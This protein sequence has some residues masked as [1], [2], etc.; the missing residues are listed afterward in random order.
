MKRFLGLLAVVAF[1]CCAWAQNVTYQVKYK[2]AY[3]MQKY[4]YI[5]SLSYAEGKILKMGDTA[6]SINGDNYVVDNK[7]SDTATDTRKMLQYT[8]HNTKGE[9]FVICFSHELTFPDEL[10][11]QVIIFNVNN[12]YHWQ[13]FITDEGK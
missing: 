13:Y 4:E 5:D 12:P 8:V 11:H 3:D 2:Y 1:S 10:A 7:D 6:I 9:Q